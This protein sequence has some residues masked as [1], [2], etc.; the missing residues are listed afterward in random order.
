MPHGK[1]LVVD[2]EVSVAHA[3][4][5]M[6]A[7]RG[8]ECVVASDTPDALWVLDHDGPFEVVVADMQMP[9]SRRAGVEVA[10]AARARHVQHVLLTAG[11]EPA[12]VGELQ[13]RGVIDH[14]FDKGAPSVV[15][16]MAAAIAAFLAGAG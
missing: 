5:R 10:R 4:E 15:S 13:S 14:F 11:D 2:D 8:I 1:V 9:S 12:D 3:L 7:R 6:L 16:A